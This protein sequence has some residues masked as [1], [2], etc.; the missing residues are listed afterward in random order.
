MNALD[1]HK[2]TH[3]HAYAHTPR[4]RTRARIEY[5][6]IDEHT[7]HSFVVAL[8]PPSLGPL[9]CDNAHCWIRDNGP[10]PEFFRFA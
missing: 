1:T 7:V 5:L 3:A 9:L 8:P 6:P 10:K 4:T 2:L